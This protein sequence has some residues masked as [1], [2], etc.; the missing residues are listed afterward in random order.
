MEVVV[1]LVERLDFSGGL[2]EASEV[3]RMAVHDLLVLLYGPRV[4]HALVGVG[5]GD[6]VR[7][8][9]VEGVGRRRVAR[10]VNDVVWME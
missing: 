3:Q 8:R 7:I 4:V 2:A 6:R 5:V 1:L 9:R 10:A